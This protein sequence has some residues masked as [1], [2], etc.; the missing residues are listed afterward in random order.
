MREELYAEFLPD[1]GAVFE[2]LQRVFVVPVIHETASEWIGEQPDAGERYVR[3]PDRYLIG[4]DIAATKD[5]F[6]ISGFNA[7]TR[8]QAFLVRMIGVPLHVARSRVV[9][10]RDRYN[11][12]TVYYDA[13][14]GWG[15]AISGDAALYANTSYIPRVWNQ[16]QKEADIF[17]A[18]ALCQR[19]GG[20]ERATGPGWYMLD[21][22]W[23]RAEWMDYQAVTQTRDG[24]DLERAK[25]GAPLRKHDDSV[26]A[27]CM[28]AERLTE[29]YVPTSVPEVRAATPYDVAWWDARRAEAKRANAGGIRTYGPRR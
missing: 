3:V 11:A 7:R 4:V 17:R 24:R 23:Q 29:P 28:V 10:L 27:A 14:G 1:E 5:A 18:K 22:P 20:D 2:N 15:A 19:A 12:A 13:T 25:Y 21:V 9:E 6:V 16:G 26:A 8:R